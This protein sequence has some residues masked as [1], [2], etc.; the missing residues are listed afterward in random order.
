VNAIPKNPKTTLVKFTRM[1]SAARKSANENV[2]Q[3]DV[4]W[5]IHLAGGRKNENEMKKVWESFRSHH[6]RIIQATL[7]REDPASSRGRQPRKAGKSS[8]PVE[9]NDS[10]FKTVSTTT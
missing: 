9:I 4:A 8:M 7:V 1:E 3:G 10:H 5:C 6:A 2:F